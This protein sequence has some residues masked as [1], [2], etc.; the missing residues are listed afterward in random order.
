MGLLLNGEG[1][2]RTENTEKAEVLNAFLASVF[3]IMHRPRNQNN[4]AVQCR[5]TQKQCTGTPGK[6]T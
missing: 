6:K 5:P 2:F 3:N 1:A 4:K